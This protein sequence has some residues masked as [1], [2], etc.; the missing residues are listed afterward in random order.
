MPG[1]AVSCLVAQRVLPINAGVPQGSV[2]APLLFLVFI[3]DL[4]DVIQNELD[5]FAD[6]ST[7]WS[8][9]HSISSRKAVADSM[10][11]DLAAIESWAS[12]W[13]VTFNAGKTES[14]IISSHQDL[15]AFRANPLDKDGKLSFGP[16]I[17]PHP[18]LVFC[19]RTLPESLSFKVVGLTFTC[20]MSWNKHISNIAKSAS[21]ALSHLYRARN[22][23]SRRTLSMIYKSHVRS[24]MEYCCPIWM[25]ASASSLALL[26]RVQAK[27]AKII[28]H[29]EAIELQSLAHRRG[30]A[31]LSAM[32]RI[33]HHTAPPRYCLSALLVLR[34]EPALART[35]AS[36]SCPA[37]TPRLRHTG[38]AAS[39]L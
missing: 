38:S 4:F 39:S 13:L 35:H 14:L 30:V 25:G 18:H 12:R 2:L 33:V 32:H 8:I 20:K 16:A 31:A 34:L 21:R 3:N 24:R 26:D 19:G 15:T 5:V 9:V 10:S 1:C 6:D 29:A 23:V 28:G 37:S 36:L 11:A 17:C 27:A 22:V 7:L